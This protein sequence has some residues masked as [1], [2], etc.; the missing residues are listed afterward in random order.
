L[1]YMRQHGG[2]GSFPPR[3][4]CRLS[5]VA[6]ECGR[7]LSEDAIARSDL[8]GGRGSESSSAMT[9]L[10]CSSAC[11]HVLGADGTTESDV[12]HTDAGLARSPVE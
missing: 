7:S 2:G 9:C 12:N 10:E 11:M 3:K 8:I 1:A 5:G 6:I 4:S